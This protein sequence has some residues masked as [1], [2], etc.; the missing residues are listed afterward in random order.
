MELI[1]LQIELLVWIQSF[2]SSRSVAILKLKSPV[3]PDIYPTSRLKIVR[4]I[5]YPK[6]LA[7]YEM[8][9]ASFRIWTR[10]AKFISHYNSHHAIRASGWN[11]YAGLNYAKEAF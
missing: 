10:V 5:S 11:E 2:P 9:T 1:P 6:V 8:Q 7:L 3:C 4:F